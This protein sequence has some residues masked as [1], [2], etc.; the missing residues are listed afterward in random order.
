MKIA[1]LVGLLLL[2]GALSAVAQSPSPAP[3]SVTVQ[4]GLVVAPGMTPCPIGMHVR[5][6]VGSQM[7]EAKDGQRTRVFAARLRLNLWAPQ[8]AKASPAQ[9]TGATVTV[10]GSN[11]KAGMVLALSN[12]DRPAEIT[13]TMDVKLGLDDDK[14]FFAELVLPGMTAA[15]RV[16]LRSITYADGSTWKVTGHPEFCQATPDPIML[17][18]GH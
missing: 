9:I 18:S 1:T 5:Q 2:Q 15:T 16:D 13:R 12:N 7:L 8:S 6:G 11:G 17:I 14:T 4:T 3:M 10:H